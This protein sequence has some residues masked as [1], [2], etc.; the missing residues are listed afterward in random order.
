[1]SR[2]KAIRLKCLDC[3]GNECN[4]VI[5]CNITNC[6]LY[7]FRSGTGKQDAKARD[8]AIK[9]YCVYCMNEHPREIALCISP[10]CSLFPYRGYNRA[11]KTAVVKKIAYRGINKHDHPEVI[12]EHHSSEK[13]S[14]KALRA[15]QLAG[16]SNNEA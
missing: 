12:Q 6:P 11:K 5:H 15:G 9:A 10:Y 14:I 13:I 4:E 16:E 1:M 8:I 7:S 2:R 3:S